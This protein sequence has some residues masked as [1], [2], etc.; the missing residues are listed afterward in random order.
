MEYKRFFKKNNNQAN[1]FLQREKIKKFFPEM[2]V[3][4]KN[5]ELFCRGYISP[6]TEENKYKLVLKYKINSSPKVWITGNNDIKKCKKH[7]YKDGSLCLYYP[8]E[9]KWSL[10]CNVH[11]T[12][13]PWT[14]EWI[15]C[16]EYWKRYGKWCAP[17][18]PHSGSK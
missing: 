8:Q 4:F 11:E 15:V 12:I 6:I 16:F 1:F 14:A 2:D 17:E 9:W 10:S 13:L 5:N 7:I 18:S 3:F